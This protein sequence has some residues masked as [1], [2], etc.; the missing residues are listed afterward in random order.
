[1]NTYLQFTSK[2]ELLDHL[3]HAGSGN[4]E[5]LGC[6]ALRTVHLDITETHSPIGHGVALISIYAVLSQNMGDHVAV[7][8]TLIH[9]IQDMEIIGHDERAKAARE[10]FRREIDERLA[11]LREEVEM[12][13]F[14]CKPGIWTHEAPLYLRKSL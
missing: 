7:Y 5:M 12:D 13:S 6:E 11:K 8:G 3:K 2:D 10:K 4:I 9:R 1:M 14:L